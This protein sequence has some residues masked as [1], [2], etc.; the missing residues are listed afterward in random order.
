M[1]AGSS[2]SKIYQ[3]VLEKMLPALSPVLYYHSIRHTM[4]VLTQAQRI[5][6]A[7]AVFSEHEI[8]LLK[9]AAL[10]HDTGFLIQYNGHEEASCRLALQE[11]P[12]FGIDNDDIAN[13]N[14]MIM[15]TRI[16]QSPPNKL[17]EVLCDADLDY[18]G[19]SDFY[20]G[21]DR[22]Y[23][24]LKAL[25]KI[26]DKMEWDK[27]QVKF[28]KQHS[29]FTHTNNTTRKPQKLIHLKSLEDKIQAY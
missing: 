25:G 15:A 6:E 14:S 28:L 24:E 23:N 1:T 26:S 16:P 11:L 3:H 21:G 12:L 18:L 8:F 19:R 17:A 5:A 20:E 29:Y 27:I 13:I 7:E 2:Y 10:F 4:D 9:I 22:L